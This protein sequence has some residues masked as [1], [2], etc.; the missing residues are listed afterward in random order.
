MSSRTQGQAAIVLTLPLLFLMT[1]IFKCGSVTE[2]Y[3]LPV[4]RGYFLGDVE[5]SSRTQGQA[6]IVLTLPLLCLMTVIFMSR[7]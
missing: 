2:K 5:M 3:R 1:V 4:E 7:S 6:A